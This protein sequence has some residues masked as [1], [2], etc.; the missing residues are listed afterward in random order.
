MRIVS[1]GESAHPGAR[2][3]PHARGVFQHDQDASN[4]RKD[5]LGY[6]VCGR[7]FLFS[8]RRW[9]WQR[10]KAAHTFS[11]RGLW[12]QNVAGEEQ[13][14]RTEGRLESAPEA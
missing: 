7:H 11:C 9:V 1:E 5:V 8:S 6:C 14:D 4:H 13:I 10:D 2:D 3:R 12:K